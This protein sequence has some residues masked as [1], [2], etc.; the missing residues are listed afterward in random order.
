MPTGGVCCTKHARNFF[1]FVFVFPFFFLQSVKRLVHLDHKNSKK[2]KTR[3]CSLAAL[4]MKFPGD[5][6]HFDVRTHLVRSTVCAC[7]CVGTKWKRAHRPMLPHNMLIIIFQFCFVIVLPSVC[8]QCIAFLIG[9]LYFTI[10][11]IFNTHG[12]IIPMWYFHQNHWCC[13]RVRMRAH[14]ACSC[15]CCASYWIVLHHCIHHR[16]QIQIDRLAK[17]NL[18][19]FI[20]ILQSGCPLFCVDAV[21]CTPHLS[22]QPTG[23]EVYNTIMQVVNGFL[24]RYVNAQKI[25]ELVF[26]LPDFSLS[27][28]VA[29]MAAEVSKNTND[30]QIVCV[31]FLIRSSSQCWNEI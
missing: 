5:L 7:V 16:N 29:M 17:R 30:N 13:V 31:R 2:V 11:I 6:W 28:E 19:E 25:F 26:S 9:L 14:T 10:I 12:T 27:D 3:K 20:E 8:G 23:V 24:E 15:A 22:L 18:N 21:L 1:P 4:Y